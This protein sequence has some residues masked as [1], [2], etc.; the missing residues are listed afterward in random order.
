VTKY[1]NEEIWFGLWCLTPLSTICLLYLWQSVLLVEETGVPGE[2][3]QVTDKLYHMMLY[4]VHLGMNRVRTHKF[5]GD[6]HWLH[7]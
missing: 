1:Y 4:R 3:H 5:S 7:K 2:N 6:G